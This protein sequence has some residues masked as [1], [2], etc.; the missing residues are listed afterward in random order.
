[1]RSK[2]VLR[3]YCDHCNKGF[4]GK[5]A[6]LE[7]EQKCFKDP[8]N[9]ACMTCCSREVNKG[10]WYCTCYDRELVQF[11]PQGE[12]KKDCIQFKNNCPQW[13]GIK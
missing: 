2:K 5:Q 7:H 10:P 4:W 11:P 13:S 9:K 1:M 8:N 12:E 3:Y 6:C